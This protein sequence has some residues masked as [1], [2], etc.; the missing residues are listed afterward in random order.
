MQ[1]VTEKEHLTVN[2]RL[3]PTAILKP[4]L[5]VGIIA[6][7]L[8]RRALFSNGCMLFLNVFYLACPVYLFGS[9]V[10]RN[11]PPF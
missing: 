3:N 1:P 10:I 4:S 8:R 11:L 9:K 2:F 6:D 5:R 7:H